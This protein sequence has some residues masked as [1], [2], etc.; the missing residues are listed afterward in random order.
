MTQL[1]LY[2][3]KYS[4]INEL[5]YDK[6]E[7]FGYENE[8]TFIEDLTFFVDKVYKLPVYDDNQKRIKQQEF[9]NVLLEKYETCIISGSNCISELEAC[10][11]SGFNSHSSND[12]VLSNGILLKKNLSDTFNKYLWSINPNTLIVEIKNN[13]DVG[14]IKKCKNYELGIEVNNEMYL[15]LLDH[16]NKFINLH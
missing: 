3:D 9:K 13:V 12:Y 16:Y 7:S 2:L 5:V 11:I 6:Y 1:E 15:N 8:Y 10:I 14:E 4:R